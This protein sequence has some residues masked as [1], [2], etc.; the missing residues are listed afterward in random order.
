MHDDS[1]CS[2][3]MGFYSDFHGDNLIQLTATYT[4]ATYT[5]ASAATLVGSKRPSEVIGNL[6]KRL[7]SFKKKMEFYWLESDWNRTTKYNESR[8]G[9]NIC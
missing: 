7:K 6:L 2:L 8:N 1:Y 5:G 9:E 4:G 3:I